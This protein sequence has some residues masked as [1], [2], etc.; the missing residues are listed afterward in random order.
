MNSP[1][2]SN[3]A[4]WQESLIW[5]GE[6]LQRDLEKSKGVHFKAHMIYTRPYPSY[7][8]YMKA[9]NGWKVPN[10]YKFSGEDNKNTN[11]HII[12]FLA[13][14]GEASTMEHMRI[15]NFLLSL[16]SSWEH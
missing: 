16:T 15:H 7:L 2:M 4:S 3:P 6:N 13:Q 8:D 12:I 1:Q 14:V 11:E 5:F 9:P 10:F